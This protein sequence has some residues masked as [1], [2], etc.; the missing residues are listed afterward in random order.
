MSFLP[1]R[2][3]PGGAFQ[4]TCT[5]RLMGPV[6]GGSGMGGTAL[7]ESIPDVPCS[8]Q[9][10]STGRLMLYK[11][12]SQSSL[13]DLYLPMRVE[14]RASGGALA[15]TVSTEFVVG[16]VTYIA[17][18]EGMAQGQSGTQLVP[19]ERLNR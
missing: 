14:N 18:G 9:A 13:F 7:A 15:I 8:L 11:A 4:D 17:V 2:P 5:V 16:S 10:M 3:I 1:P 12:P 19:V 6:T